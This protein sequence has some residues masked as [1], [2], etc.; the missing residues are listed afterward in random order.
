[1]IVLEWS[2]HLEL[3]FSHSRAANSKVGGQVWPKIT[4]IKVLIVVPDTC[5][6]NEDPFEN[7]STRV[8][9]TLLPL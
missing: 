6:N 8:L 1:M 4:L 3:Y 2:K 5:K 9:T 7:E